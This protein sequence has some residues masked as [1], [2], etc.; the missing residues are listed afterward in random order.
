MTAPAAQRKMAFCLLTLGPH[1]REPAPVNLLQRRLSNS[2]YAWVVLAASCVMAGLAFGSLI[3]VSVFLR[4]LEAEFGWDRSATSFA[5]SSGAFMAGVMGIG[6]GRL[7]DRISPRPLLVMGAVAI[8]AG[9][10][11]LSQLSA[12]W[13]LYALYAVLVGGIGGGSC[14]VPL[15]T[16]VGFWFQRNRGVAIGMVLAGQSLGGALMPVLTRILVDTMAWR[17]A[18]LALGLVIWAV[19]LPLSALV[20]QPPD[21]AA[22]RAAA[23]VGAVRPA[24][25]PARLT[26]TLCT[27]IVCCCI[28][29]SIPIVHVYPLAVEAGLPTVQAATVLGVLMAVSIVGRVGI[30][31]VADRVGG[32]R[33]LLLASGV[34]T[35]VIFWFSQ[36]GSFAGLLAVA[37][38][39]G[40]GYGGVIPSYAIIIREQI[41]LGRVGMATGLVFFF[42]N[43]GMGLGGYLGGLFY[44]LSGAYPASFAAGAAA[45]VLNLLIVGSLLV[46]TLRARTAPQP[47]AA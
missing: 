32:V 29:M 16:N 6:M 33:S 21:M 13:Q 24:L 5:Y 36:V 14:L 2:A 41:P 27:A 7:V 12:Q 25:S 38:L 44:D 22:Q 26:A 18:Y 31:K 1:T 11:L 28:C 39:F 45:G 37:T 35:V 15:V 3:S 42:G 9:H 8:G 43:L 46:A 34:Q 10:L 4:P 17:D 40:V 30:G 23:A 20:R 19:M 47:A